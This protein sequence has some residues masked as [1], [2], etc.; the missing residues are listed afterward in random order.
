MHSGSADGGRT[1]HSNVPKLE[2]ALEQIARGLNITSTKLDV[3]GKAVLLS[4][5][6]DTE[7]HQTKDGNYHM[8]D[9]ARY[10]KQLSCRY[11]IQF[12]WFL[13]DRIFPAED[14]S[15][16]THLTKAPQGIFFRYVVCQK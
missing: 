6:T 12:V 11:H 3:N 7:I 5:C 8:L 2:S 9:L 10:V 4:T 15:V 16:C 1:I 14:P 13:V